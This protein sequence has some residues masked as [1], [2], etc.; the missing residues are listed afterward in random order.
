[1]CKAELLP[2]RRVEDMC[3]QVRCSF[4]RFGILSVNAAEHNSS[5]GHSGFLQELLGNRYDLWTA[6][7]GLRRIRQG[8]SAPAG[9]PASP[10]RRLIRQIRET[11]S[12]AGTQYQPIKGGFICTVPVATDDGTVVAVSTLSHQDAAKLLSRSTGILLNHE[13]PPPKAAASSA[14]PDQVT[15]DEA[16]EDCRLRADESELKWLSDLPASVAPRS[17]DHSLQA[18]ADRILPGLRELIHAGSLILRYSEPDRPPRESGRDW[19][20]GVA[21]TPETIESL[22][23]EHGRAALRAGGK[24]LNFTSPD[25]EPMSQGGVVSAIVVPVQWPGRPHGW[26]IAANKDLSLLATGRRQSRYG[27]DIQTGDIEFGAAE[28]S[29]VRAAAAVLAT[30]SGI[31]D[32]LSDREK[33]LTGVVRSLVNALD[34]KDSY[35]CGHSDRVA[36]FARLTA[37]AMHLDESECE[38]IYMAGLLHDIGKVGIPDEVLN[39]PDKLTAYETELIQ[40]HPVTG[41]E[42]LRHLNSF[43][44]VLPGVLHHHESFD[45]TGYPK[46]LTG[47]AIPLAA[48]ILAVADAWDAMTSNRSYRSGMAPSRAR[49]IL[50]EGAGQQWDPDCVA[51]FLTCMDD[52]RLRTDFSHQAPTAPTMIRSLAVSKMAGWPGNSQRDTNTGTSEAFE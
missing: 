45:G 49:S 47:N 2:E 17:G 50:Q 52:V 15:P 10:N 21:I 9:S 14:V 1:M 48:R 39:K 18:V 43:E 37:A 41:Y 7:G 4:V 32:L 51:A 3:A 6:R 33:L 26:L 40:R 42:I 46:G 19:S 27:A 23:D 34:A 24:C 29:L 36:E 16:S 11:F 35:T 22:I 20:A 31:L 28:I 12:T 8:L 25:F 38:E 13:V 5:S 30:N 44:Y